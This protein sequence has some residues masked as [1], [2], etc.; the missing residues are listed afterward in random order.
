MISVVRSEPSGDVRPRQRATRPSNQS[1]VIA[2]MKTAVAHQ[3]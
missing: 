1:V 3:S 2:A